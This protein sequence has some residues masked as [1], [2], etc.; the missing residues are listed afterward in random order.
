MVITLTGF[1]GCGKSSV[2][3][4]LA[5]RLG[6][7]FVDLDC[8]LEHKKGMSSPDIFATEGEE[9][10]RALE[11]ECVRDVVVMSQIT[12]R[13]AVLALGGGSMTY[14][15]VRWLILEQTE[16]F[17]LKASLETCLSRI[18]DA[19]SRPVL[20]ELMLT[21][22]EASAAPAKKRGDAIAADASS[23][24]KLQALF[25]EREK[26]YAMS[27]HTIY[28]DGLTVE[29]TAGAIKTIVEEI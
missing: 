22:E 23:T 28:N 6:W 25:E 11:A 15:A 4:V 17:W 5:D 12:G 18:G 2:G 24:D 27:R 1:M 19:A 9:Y 21:G 26:V 20:A 7:D 8:Y 14:T 16:S 10:F 13:D 29:E 3:R